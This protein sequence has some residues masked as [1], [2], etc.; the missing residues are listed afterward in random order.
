MM[1]GN[2]VIMYCRLSWRTLN[3]QGKRKERLTSR[4]CAA[5]VSGV[6]KDS[7]SLWLNQH[8]EM[9]EEVAQIAIQR[10]QN[11]QRAGKKSCA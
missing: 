5:F 3:F 6:A 4:E 9:G 11:R 7:F 2:V 8:P 1:Y 10:A